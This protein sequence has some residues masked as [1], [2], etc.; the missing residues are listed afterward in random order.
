MM[1]LRTTRRLLATSGVALSL[2][3][4]EGA[5]ESSAPLTAECIDTRGSAPSEAWFCAE[6]YT[7]ECT[8]GGATHVD[9]VFLAE[10]EGNPSCGDHRFE[11][12]DEGPFA[13][14]L[15]AI[16]V[17]A[18]ADG[19][20]DRA[21]VCT[22][23][24]AVVDRTPPTATPRRVELWP[25]NHRMHRVRPEDC[26]EIRDACDADVTVHFLW[27]SSDEVANGLGDGNHAPDI[28]DL[29]CDGV[30]LRAERAGPGDGRVYRLGY[31]AVDDAGHAIEGVCEV[32]VPHDQSGRAAVHSGEAYRTH[33][34]ADAACL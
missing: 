9:F 24:L 22:S 28:Q 23:T 17:Y 32:I 30:S 18:V 31:R 3:C 11:V 5:R 34:A 21:L 29:G 1:N 7:V 26:V 19:S 14:G 15:H 27:A 6:P 13:P 20:A 4:A 10:D 8:G 33:V 25:P 12:S 2:A 16:E